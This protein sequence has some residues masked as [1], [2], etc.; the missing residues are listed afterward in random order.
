ML[1]AKIITEL[2]SEKLESL[3]KQIDAQAVWTFDEDEQ[4][5]ITAM[6]YS[7]SYTAF[8]K[9]SFIAGENGRNLEPLV[10]VLIDI[11]SRKGE[12]G[13]SL[14]LQ[15]LF[16]KN[17]VW[18]K[19]FSSCVIDSLY[20]VSAFMRSTT[21]RLLLKKFPD[22]FPAVYSL[23]TGEEYLDVQN[24]KLWLE[25]EYRKDS[26]KIVDVK[27]DN[28]AAKYFDFFVCKKRLIRSLFS[29][30]IIQEESV[31]AARKTI[32]DEDSLVFDD[33]EFRYQLANG[34]WK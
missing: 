33:L 4:S 18:R 17:L 25:G 21:I 32:L 27:S 19:E 10:S 23:A 7:D 12:R 6:L 29:V 34:Y 16:T 1:T 9:A 15:Y 28:P 30:L 5:L 2:S 3:L 26:E 24:A 8:G 13:R 20:D 14:L 31:Q 22:I 11:A